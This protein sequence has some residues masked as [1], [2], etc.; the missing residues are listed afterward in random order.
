MEGY[1]K[2][3]TVSLRRRYIYVRLSD[4][5]HSMD[6]ID[7]IYRINTIDRIDSLDTIDTIYTIDRIVGLIG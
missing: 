2:T 4:R 3:Y 1:G 6:T 5:I 7:R